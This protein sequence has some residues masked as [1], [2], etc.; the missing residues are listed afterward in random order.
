MKAPEL[1]LMMLKQ[2]VS[3]GHKAKYVLFASWFSTPKGI[4]DIKRTLGMDII[5][6]VKKSG[7]VYYEYNG[8]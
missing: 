8:E 1:I 5:A 3:A 2:A 6:M 7:K 4:M